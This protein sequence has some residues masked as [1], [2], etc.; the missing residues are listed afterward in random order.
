MSK[1]VPAP[2]HTFAALALIA[3]ALLL[4][5]FASSSAFAARPL[6]SIERANNVMQG[7]YEYIDIT[8]DPNGSSLQSA[9]FDLLVT[10]DISALTFI[11]A[12]P[13]QLLTDCDWQF[14]VYRTGGGTGCAGSCPPGL[15]RIVALGDS[16]TVPGE[17]S[18]NLGDNGA[19]QIVS[20]RFLVSN[21]STYGCQL[22]PIEFYWNDCA[23]NGFSS[24]SGATYYLADTVYSALGEWESYQVPQWLGTSEGAPQLCFPDSGFANLPQR[25]VNYRHGGMD[26]VCSDSISSR[27]DLNLN[28]IAYEVADA[29]VFA[30]YFLY[31]L[32]ALDPNP[33]IRQTQIAASDI[34]ADG[35]VLE[36]QDFAYLLRVIA[37]DALPFPKESPA[38]SAV[39]IFTQNTVAKTVT[40]HYPQQLAGG[41]F[42]FIGEIVPTF[43]PGAPGNFVQDYHFENGV[44]RV[45]LS[46]S[47]PHNSPDTLWFSYTGNGTLASVE[48]ADFHDT[49][50]TSQIV[51]ESAPAECGDVN[52]DGDVNISDIVAMIGHIFDIWPGPFDPA[53]ADVDCSGSVTISDAVYLLQYVF[54]GGS[55]PCA[56]CP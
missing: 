50:I 12:S 26:I 14:F 46:S 35:H 44:T 43:L 53:L 51:I 56:N 10:Y 37:G 2:R 30:N 47:T 11:S 6:V 31:G 39:A 19:G 36:F 42:V 29:V 24:V 41:Y 8:F 25:A 55:T 20:M 4:S 3:F 7:M 52:Q 5:T 22:L 23:D 33:L 17:H 16:P 40:A 1:R 9:G 45:L 18:C 49:R 21:S 27:G 34:N 28:G 54:A 15:V 32:A 13:G 38:D 48:T